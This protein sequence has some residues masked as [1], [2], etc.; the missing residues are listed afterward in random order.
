MRLPINDY[1]LAAITNEVS[2]WKS[3]GYF[4]EYDIEHRRGGLATLSLENIFLFDGSIT[5][6]EI[7]K[8]GRKGFL[9]KKS[10]W[11]IQL[12]SV[13]PYSR[14]L[15][16]HGCITGTMLAITINDAQKDVRHGFLS[17]LDLDSAIESVL[18]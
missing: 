16:Q 1:D 2:V 6:Y 18:A 17:I 9:G 5:I 7:H 8:I 10:R 15:V 13:Y 14:E 4:A 3:E 11:V 12:N